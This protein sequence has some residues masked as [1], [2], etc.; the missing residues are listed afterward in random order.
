[1]RPSI[2]ESAGKFKCN[3]SNT[4]TK[5]KCQ[6]ES[7]SILKVIEHITLQHFSPRH[8][9]SYRRNVERLTKPTA[10]QQR[11]IRQAISESKLYG[12]PHKH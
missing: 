3:K 5:E 4:L 9:P 11:E 10:V 2:I 6:F 7:E 8:K 1:M 12:N